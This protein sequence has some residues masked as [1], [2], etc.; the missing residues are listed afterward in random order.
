MGNEQAKPIDPAAELRQRD[1]KP[2]NP[3]FLKGV[4]HNLKIVI[5]G[6]T[7]TGKTA[8]Y[9]KLQGLLPPREYDATPQINIAHMKWNGLGD[10]GSS[11]VKA[12]LWDVV[13]RGRVR[14]KLGTHL[15]LSNV[16]NPT[17]SSGGPETDGDPAD[18][19]DVSLDAETINVYRDC[20]CVLLLFDVAK[21]WTFDYAEK[22]LAQIPY[23]VPVVLVGNFKARTKPALSDPKGMTKLKSKRGTKAGSQV[24]NSIV[25]AAVAPAKRL[26]SM[27]DVRKVLG[28]ALRDRLR[29]AERHRQEMRRYTLR[30]SPETTNHGMKRAETSVPHPITAD[31]PAALLR[32]CEGDVLT[33]ADLQRLAGT[34]PESP[35]AIPASPITSPS[36][37]SASASPLVS[38]VFSTASHRPLPPV[39]HAH[40]SGIYYS[41][42]LDYITAFLNII[43]LRQQAEALLHR[44]RQCEREV[45]NRLQALNHHPGDD[46][47]EDGDE[48]DSGGGI[49]WDDLVRQGG[50][51]P[52]PEVSADEDH[53]DDMFDRRFDIGDQGPGA[54]SAPRHGQG[55]QNTLPTPRPAI[56]VERR[57]NGPVPGGDAKPV[58]LSSPTS[59]VF[60][61]PERH[62]RPVVAKPLT[63]LEDDFFDEDDDDDDTVPKDPMV[64][65]HHPPAASGRPGGVVGSRYNR[66]DSTKE[67]ERHYYPSNPMV[68][69]DEDIDDDDNDDDD[70]HHHPD[71]AAPISRLRQAVKPPS[72]PGA[73]ESTVRMSY[74]HRHPRHRSPSPTTTRPHNQQSPWDTVES[75]T[76]TSKGP[77]PTGHGETE[78][79]TA[80]TQGPIAPDHEDGDTNAQLQFRRAEYETLS[81]NE[82][83]PAD[84]PWSI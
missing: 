10:A 54:F 1:L 5:R 24:G 82:S 62:H 30:A 19:P 33:L 18:E 3:A 61:A 45:G 17:G 11:V 68:A 38:P 70:H 71:Y 56:E 49:D 69:A 76:N 29:A 15:K 36:P 32:Y 13:Q 66:P 80:L 26:V 40:I 63:S 53:L 14:R 64:P 55:K 48:D 77:H 8:L 21:P 74:G 37:T 78:R 79:S 73:L 28:R 75:V 6:D 42:V 57:F 58:P 47:E 44:A 34:G 83:S 22:E 9:H 2:M 72:S 4:Q 59:P 50:R 84:N 20:Q 7:M 41:A 39:N 65:L 81:D 16:T 46:S 60:A 12:E 52:T 31:D 51:S 25:A 67:S 27:Q 35:P 43:L 23:N